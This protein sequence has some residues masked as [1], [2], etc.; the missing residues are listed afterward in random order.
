[1][2]I[3]QRLAKEVQSFAKIKKQEPRI[4]QIKICE[5]RGSTYLD[6]LQPS[7]QYFTSSQFFSHF[8]RQ[9]NSLPQVAQGLDGR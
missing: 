8:L 5:I 3:T 2:V 4:S 9:V 6:F 7:L 1:L